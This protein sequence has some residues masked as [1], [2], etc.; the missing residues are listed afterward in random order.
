LSRISARL[1]NGSITVNHATSKDYLVFSGFFAL[2][3]ADGEK[4]VHLIIKRD[5]KNKHPFAEP[6]KFI[7]LWVQYAERGYEQWKTIKTLR[8]VQYVF[9]IWHPVINLMK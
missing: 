2:P 9:A 6:D 8:T 5:L 7:N 3:I 4:I 1:A